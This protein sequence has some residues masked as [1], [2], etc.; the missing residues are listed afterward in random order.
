MLSKLPVA[1]QG[2]FVFSHPT[3]DESCSFQIL[4]IADRIGLNIEFTKNYV[5]V[6]ELKSLKPLFGSKQSQWF[7]RP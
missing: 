5:M 7:I 1:G 6:I 2:I 3:T 4:N